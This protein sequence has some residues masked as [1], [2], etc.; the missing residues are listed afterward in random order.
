MYGYRSGWYGRYPS[1]SV[2]GYL[3]VGDTLG[4]QNANE[5]VYDEGF[6]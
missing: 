3:L 6:A 4:A 1:R 2:D 5:G